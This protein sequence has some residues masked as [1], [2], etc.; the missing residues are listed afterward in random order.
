MNHG[1]TQAKGLFVSRRAAF[2]R[3]QSNQSIQNVTDMIKNYEKEIKGYKHR[4]YQL[5]QAEIK[6]I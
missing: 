3:K 4:I 5:E 2:E 6:R 1:I